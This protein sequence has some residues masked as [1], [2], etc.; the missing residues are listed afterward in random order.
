MTNNFFKRLFCYKL[1][2]YMYLILFLVIFSSIDV[3]AESPSF[4]KLQLGASLYRECYYCHSLKPG[5]HLTGPSL[6]EL[7]EKKAGQVKGY[8]LYSDALKEKSMEWNESALKAW[9]E[10]PKTLVSGTTMT[11]GGFP[12]KESVEA[13]LEFLKIAMGPDGY[14]KVITDKLTDK[15]TADGQLPKN[16]SNPEK[17]DIITEISHCQNNYILTDATGSRTK[18][19]ELN[20]DFKVDSGKNGPPKG[21][22]VRIDS[23]SMGDRFSIIFHDA[24]EISRRLKKC[25]TKN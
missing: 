22:P 14:N 16:L 10:S 17:R 8:S 18:H 11:F 20:I 24:G 13:L 1:L 6:A 5:V 7:W 2:G 23:G 9:I 12:E 25:K 4:K 3:F 19:W 21:K 15:K